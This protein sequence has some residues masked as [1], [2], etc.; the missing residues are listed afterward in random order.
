MIVDDEVSDGRF[1]EEQGE[2]EGPGARLG[3]PRPD[4]PSD[5]AVHSD[6]TASLSPED[7]RS[8]E[9]SS[10]APQLYIYRLGVLRS[11]HIREIG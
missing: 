10:C 11:M 3:P 6:L 1:A 2:V 7:S 9:S 8:H 4:D 5:S